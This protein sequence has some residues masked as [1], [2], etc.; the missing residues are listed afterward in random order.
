V[1]PERDLIHIRTVHFPR[2]KGD[3]GRF[4]APVVFD[5]YFIVDDL[6]HR[7]IPLYRISEKEA[8]NRF[9]DLDE[10]KVVHRRIPGTER[11]L[12]E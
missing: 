2:C 12:K 8:E 1:D 5:D 9:M 6:A 7:R 3:R 11:F 4:G 10:A